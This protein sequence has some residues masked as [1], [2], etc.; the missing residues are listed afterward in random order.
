MNSLIFPSFHNK[1]EKIM[2]YIRN[3]IKEKRRKHARRKISRAE[4]K[5][6]VEKLNYFTKDIEWQD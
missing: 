2:I 5:V 6:G 3:G 4:A 1:K